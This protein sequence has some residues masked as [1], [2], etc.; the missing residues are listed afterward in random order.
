MRLMRLVIVVALVVA[1]LAAQAQE[2]APIQP[3]ETLSGALSVTAPAATYTFEV[4]SGE[5]VTIRLSSLDF[6]SYLQLLDE[7]GAL[8]AEDDDG[9][10]GL[11]AQIS[12]F[13]LPADGAYTIVV[14]SARHSQNADQVSTGNYTLTL[15][16]GGGLAQNPIQVGQT[17]SGRLDWDAPTAAYTFTAHAGDSV[18][19]AVA[20]RDFDSFV[21]VQDA[22]GDEIASDDD[23]GGSLNARI[24]PLNLPEDGTYTIVVSSYSSSGAAGAF[25]LTLSAPHVNQINYGEIVE[26]RIPKEELFVT[27]N[28][29]GAAG[30]AVVITMVSSD[31]YSYMELAAPADPSLPIASS[32]YYYESLG[33]GSRIGPLVLPESGAYTLTVGDSDDEHTGRF[34]LQVKKI[35]LNQLEYG[36]SAGLDIGAADDEIYLSF[37]GKA[38]EAA[39]IW[40]ESGQTVDTS[41]L[42][43]GP[44][45]FQV[46]ADD[47][48]GGGFDPEIAR[49]VLNEDGVYYIL[50]ENLNA[51]SGQARVSLE[52]V[53]LPSL[54]AGPLQIRLSEDHLQEV[55]TFTGKAGS[56]ARLSLRVLGLTGTVAEPSVTVAQGAE[57]L[58]YASAS[59]VSTLSIEFLVP[60][61]GP[62]NV[63]IEDLSY[64][65]VTLEVS[66]QQ[67]ANA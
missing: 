28:F 37:E 20:S 29:Q 24:G 45:N 58:A 22:H 5:T 51:D 38:G 63:T 2:R 7:D 32:Q 35:R 54:D 33:I 18:V 17:V 15:E 64:G 21:S 23:S 9:G 53:A 14:T 6:D 11:D 12:A 27:Y 8:L 13:E 49:L 61:D 31:L 42:V 66:L 44:G 3:G 52:A 41:L 59:Y 50:V 19:I 62:V 57:T 48:S 10:G 1:G 40:V 36:Q 55:V 60:A 47:D 26:G 4:R 43:I 65:R 30:D 34:T 39:R 16:G 46:A 56:R 67:G 25:E